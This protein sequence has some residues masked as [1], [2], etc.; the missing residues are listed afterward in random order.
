MSRWL[1]VVALALASCKSGGEYVTNDRGGGGAD[2]GETNGRSLDLVSN[3]PEGDDWEIRIRGSS[4]WASYGDQDK[5]K[6]LPPVNLDRMQTEKIWRLIDELDVAGR[7]KGKK[8]EDDGFVTLVLREPGADGEE[9][10]IHT[11]YISR[12][13]EDEG[14]EELA[15]YLQNLIKRYHKVDAEF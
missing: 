13:A 7:K 11:I 14:L 2:R 9:A 3:R 12:T 8:D 5:I 15:L 1:I 10:E 6:T 4:L